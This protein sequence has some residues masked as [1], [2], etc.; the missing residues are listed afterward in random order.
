MPK[1]ERDHGRGKHRTNGGGD[2][3]SDEQTAR[4]T[5][6]RMALGYVPAQ[7]VYVAAALELADL[8]HERPRGHQEL[9]AATGAHAPSLLRVMRGMVD[10]GLF[11]R[12]REGRFCLAPL[13]RPLRKDDPYSMRDSIVLHGG[14]LTWR[15]WGDLLHSVKTGETA[16]EHAFGM[17]F[18]EYLARNPETAATFHRAP[19]TAGG[20]TELAEAL[21]DNVDLRGVS[22]VVD[23]G[24]SD[25][26]M[27][28]ALLLAHPSLTGVLF[29]LAP[30]VAKAR[31]RLSAGPLTARCEFVAGDFFEGVPEGGDLYL[32]ARVLHDWDHEHCVTILRNCRR[33]VPEGGRLLVLERV[34]GVERANDPSGLRP[35]VRSDIDM[36][37]TT[38]G[39]ERTERQ[40]RAVLSECGF[41]L[42]GLAPIP[43]GI[44][45]ILEAKP[46]VTT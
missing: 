34:L 30:V 8:L 23:V 40:Y 4:E 19:R 13:G 2:T 6:R 7:L 38:G 16:F 31:E 18:F 10:L 12:D 28:E 43:L 44:A 37:A 17:P 32:L 20:A 9:A 24:G 45:D 25:G 27:I 15:A 3:V 39:R 42:S 33:A 35:D 36:L 14:E 41:A 5:L 11:E 1:D 21:A 22:R 29:D 46:D 26:A